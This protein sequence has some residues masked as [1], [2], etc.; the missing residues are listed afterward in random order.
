MRT[1]I[2]LLAVLAVVSLT[3]APVLAV[4]VSA[5][6]D[7]RLSAPAAGPSP[8][9]RLFKLLAYGLGAIGAIRI[10][11]TGSLANKFAQR[12]GAAAGDYKEGVSQAG[13]D[14]ETNTKNAEAS[15]EQ[16]VQQSIARKAYG[17]GVGE[18]GGAKYVTRAVNLG[19]QRYGPGV[20]A[21]KDEWAK[22]TGPYLQ[23]LAGLVLPPKGPRRSPANQQRANMVAMELG[24]M[25][26]QG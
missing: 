14:W 2:R 26:E 22:N 11:D 20:A 8:A 25:K 15:Y 16:G 4:S 23:K 24:K 12:A 1:M 19:S 21:G 13:G 6:A 5:P 3:A 10:R 18:A 17:K 7:T 9:A